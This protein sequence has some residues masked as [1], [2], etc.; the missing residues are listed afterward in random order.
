MK[1][2]IA[3]AVQDQVFEFETLMADLKQQKTIVSANLPT[4]S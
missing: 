4:D 3:K 1:S 2:E